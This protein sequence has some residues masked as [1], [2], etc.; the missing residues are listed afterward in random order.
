MKKKILLLLVLTLSIGLT[1]C[2]KRKDYD[3]YISQQ[4]YVNTSDSWSVDS[5]NDFICVGT[6]KQFDE[7]TQEYTVTL[8]F[9]KIEKG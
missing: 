8:K 5:F 7:D 4:G 6:D 3:I 9:K 2:D 1:A